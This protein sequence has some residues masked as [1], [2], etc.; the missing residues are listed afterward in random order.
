M[1]E[2]LKLEV[3]R[4]MLSDRKKKKLTQGILDDINKLV[5]DPNYG[6]EL[7]ENYVNFIGILREKHRFSMEQYK[8]A[9]MFYTLVESG[10]ALI[11][12]YIQVFP[13]RVIYRKKVYPE[14]DMTTDLA[15]EASRYNRS[16]L[17]TE[18]RKVDTIS[19][20]LIHRNLLHEAILKQATLMRTARSELVQQKASETLMRELKPDEDTNINLN[21]GDDSSKILQELRRATAELAQEQ[22]VKISKGTP[23]KRIA[24]SRIF[25][26]EVT[27]VDE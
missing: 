21:I 18:I 24:E 5:K 17:V 3:V 23:V 10:I 8:K 12:A 15:H 22:L 13:D 14:R 27:V 9:I 1:S 16:N 26:G 2:E 6:E 19:V 4:E 20:K 25:Q 7:A 11:H